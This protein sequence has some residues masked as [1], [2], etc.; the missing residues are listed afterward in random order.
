MTR[1]KSSHSKIATRVL[2]RVITTVM[3]CSLDGFWKGL[4][5]LGIRL[6]PISQRALFQHVDTL[7]ITIEFDWLK[8]TKGSSARLELDRCKTSISEEFR[9]LFHSWN[10]SMSPRN[11]CRGS[12]GL[13]DQS[14]VL[15]WSK[16]CPKI[17]TPPPGISCRE[18]LTV[19]TVPLMYTLRNVADFTTHK[20]VRYRKL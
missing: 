8:V 2:I 16:F 12:L 13:M 5:S 10:P 4:P 15:S 9:A 3:K 20:C 7:P 18:M 6:L 14:V 17:R 1:L 19:V 11:P